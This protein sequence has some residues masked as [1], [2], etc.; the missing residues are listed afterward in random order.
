LNPTGSFNVSSRIAVVAGKSAEVSCKTD[1]SANV[2]YWDHYFVTSNNGSWSSNTTR[3][4]N[5]IDIRDEFKSNINWT[6]NEGGKWILHIKL[7]NISNSGYYKC[8]KSEQPS[9]PL[10]TPTEIISELIVF[11]KK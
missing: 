2:K 7:V 9:K 1:D 10:I 6:R 8:V 11:G 5:G 3:I 4:Y